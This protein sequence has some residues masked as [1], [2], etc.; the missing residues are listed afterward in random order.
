MV[1]KFLLFLSCELTYFGV[2]LLDLL[3][4]R[5]CPCWGLCDGETI[6]EG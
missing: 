3:I 6:E 1:G 2:F 5:S 4:D